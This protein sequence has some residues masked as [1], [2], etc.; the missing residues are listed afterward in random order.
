MI[1]LTRLLL[2][3]ALFISPFSQAQETNALVLD[4]II[5]QV[6]EEIVLQSEL[7]RA[8]RTVVAQLQKQN[9]PLPPETVLNKQVLENL[10]MMKL[11]LQR[12][13]TSGL[14][15]SNDEVDGAVRRVA[16]N[17]QLSM[18]QLRQV[19]QQDGVSFDDFWED[20]RNELTVTQLKQRISRSRVDITES[21]IDLFLASNTGQNKEFH[22]AHILIPLPRNPSPEDMENAARHI[23]RI[24][25]E[26]NNGMDF[27]Q[28]AVSY[29]QGQTA[30][31]GGDLGWRP[32]NKMPAAMVE[33]LEAMDTNEVSEP[34]RGPGGLH[35]LKLIETRESQHLVDEIN[36]RH[37]LVKTDDIVSAEEA[38][39]KAKGIHDR[40]MADPDAFADIAKNESD[41]TAT[42]SNGG[43]MDWQPV[44]SFGG[45]VKDVLNGLA[46]KEVSEPFQT[47]MGWHIL[48][49]E[50]RRNQDRTEEFTRQKAREAIHAR[51]S[52]YEVEN[53]LRQMRDE[54]YIKYLIDV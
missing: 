54:A 34:I 52:E 5:A 35:L 14:R 31:K 7:D 27:S 43:D 23:Q 36:A 48:K 10:V 50:D 46:I 37:I 11:Q 30:L 19:L 17:N 47:N 44:Q 32:A 2:L 16:S 40:L 1:K 4:Q 22:L 18:D 8:K 21:E 45:R 33:T 42:S 3:S 13:K 15:I 53:F 20:L 12:A 24:Q 9:T 38:Y 6:E 41:D 25:T 49:L 28:A 29:S 26:I 51:K 39:Q